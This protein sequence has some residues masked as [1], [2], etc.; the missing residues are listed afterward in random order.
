MQ[1]MDEHDV[2][3]ENHTH[4]L[5]HACLNDILTEYSAWYTDTTDTENINKAHGRNAW[6]KDTSVK[7]QENRQLLDN[8]EAYAQNRL[9]ITQS[10]NNRLGLT[11]ISLLGAQSVTVATVQSNQLTTDFP[12]YFPNSIV[13]GQQDDYDYQDDREKDLY[14][15]DG[16]TDV[17]TPHDD[18]DNNEDNE[19]D[20]T[21]GK[22]QRK[23]F[24]TANIIRKEMTKQR[25]ADVLKK[26]QEKEK[27]KSQAEKHNDKI[28]N[29]NRPKPHKSK[30][31]ASHPD[32][33][34][35]STKGRR[36]ARIPLDN[37]TLIDPQSD[38]GTQDE[39]ILTD[40]NDMVPDDGEEPL[41]PDKIGF[42][43]FFLKVQGNLPDLMGIGDD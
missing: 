22:R 31:K 8:M 34:K 39:D 36:M 14:Q 41:G 1:P 35:R 16:T 30:G 24:A 23:T 6:Q 38:E 4:S 29:A 37:N 20:N 11:E 13:T 33:I 2:Y 32:Q 42:Y 27:A 26:Q 43:T 21:A 28:D 5:Y 12:N 19:S 25:H 10:L 18:S 7:T 9:N 40:D 3:A 15:V 17:Q